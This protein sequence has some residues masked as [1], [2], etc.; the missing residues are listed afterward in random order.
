MIYQKKKKKKV[1][2]VLFS[3]SVLETQEI[4]DE[5]AASERVFAASP[6]CEKWILTCAPD[7]VPSPTPSTMDT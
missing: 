2:L 4:Q 7:P 6:D 3:L 1:Y 5:M